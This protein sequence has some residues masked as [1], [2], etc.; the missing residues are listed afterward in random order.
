MRREC[1][2]TEEI[3]SVTASVKGTV[4]KREKKHSVTASQKGEAQKDATQRRP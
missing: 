4:E 1:K 3:L 2:R